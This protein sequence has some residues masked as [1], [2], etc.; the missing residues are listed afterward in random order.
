MILLFEKELF[1]REL[2]FLKRLRVRARQNCPLFAVTLDEDI[3]QL[4]KAIEEINVEGN[5]ALSSKRTE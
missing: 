1:H 2:T 5:T 3:H 4:E